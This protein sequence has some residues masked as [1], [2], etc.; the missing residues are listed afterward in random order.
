MCLLRNRALQE[1]RF[2]LLLFTTKND[3]GTTYAE[4]GFDLINKSF[5]HIL[6]RT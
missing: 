3:L 6:K 2:F 4:G 1:A 5:S